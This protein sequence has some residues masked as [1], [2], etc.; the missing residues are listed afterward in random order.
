MNQKIQ[1][2]QRYRCSIASGATG[3]DFKNTKVYQSQTNPYS[4]V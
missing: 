3:N 1:I 2:S 4:I